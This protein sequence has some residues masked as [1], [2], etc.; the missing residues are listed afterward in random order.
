MG[1]LSRDPNDPIVVDLVLTDLG[2]QRLAAATSS[3]QDFDVV[4]F[5]ASDEDIDYSSFDDVGTN[6][7]T[8][9]DIV[10]R[11]V[12]RQLVFEP[13]TAGSTQVRTKLIRVPL[14]AISSISKLPVYN[15]SPG[16][17]FSMAAGANQTVTFTQAFDDTVQPSLIDDSFI[18]QFNPR[19]IRLTSG[20]ASSQADL[21]TDAF[22][23][24]T[25][26]F[27][28]TRIDPREGSTLEMRVFTVFSNFTQAAAQFGVTGDSLQT[29]ITVTGKNTGISRTIT[30]TITRT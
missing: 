22:Q 24:G 13:A 12:R 7:L 21:T 5:S 25:T 1:I 11:I 4:Q 18:V 17:T 23:V 3:T 14:N 2:R 15:I 8:F 29:S 6:G 28:A 10:A 16:L 27:P 19:L 20:G 9:E 26:R 30:I